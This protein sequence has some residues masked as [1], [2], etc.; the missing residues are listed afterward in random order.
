[1]DLDQEPAALADELPAELLRHVL[2]ADRP[3]LEV[4]LEGVELVHEIRVELGLEVG[5]RRLGQVGLGGAQFFEEHPDLAPDA[6]DLLLRLGVGR[7]GGCQ[8]EAPLQRLKGRREAL[9]VH[10]LGHPDPHRSHERREVPDDLD[11]LRLVVGNEEEHAVHLGHRGQP[12]EHVVL[13]PQLVERVGRGQPGKPRASGLGQDLLLP[14]DR[15][16]AFRLEVQKVVVEADRGDRPEREGGEEAGRHEDALG[17][18][19]EPLQQRHPDLLELQG[20]GH[21]ALGPAGVAAIHEHQQGGEERHHGQPGQQ[22]AR[23]GD[24]AEL[25]DAAEIGQGQHVE[26]PRGRQ[27]AQENPGAGSGRGEFQG[28]LQVSPEKQLLLVPEEEVDPVVDPDPDDDRDEHHREQREVPDGQRGDAH[29][30][31]QAHRQD[32][33]HQERLSRALEGQEQEAEGE[34]KGQ[35]RGD[36]AVPERRGHL[37]VGER[38]HSG[39]PH[40]NAGELTSEAGDDAPDRGDRLLVAGEAALRACGLHED[41]QQTLVVREEIPGVA[42][43]ATVQREERPPGR[44]VRGRVVEPLRDLRQQLLEEAQVHRPALLEAEVEELG[45]EGRGDLRIDARDELV[46]GGVAG[47]IL[48]ELLVVED[49]VADLPQLVRRKVQ[50]CSPLEALRIDPV[51]HPP[52]LHRTAL[53]LAHEAA[54]VG[55]GLLQ[56]ASLDHDRDVLELTEVL[57]VL[58]EQDG[59]PL[60]GRQEVAGGRLEGQPVQRVGDRQGGEGE[61]EECRQ[62]RAPAGH[63]NQ[64]AEKPPCP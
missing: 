16:G 32:A 19:G 3:G 9:K 29:R 44:A 23:P 30:P 38:G 34:R 60:A 6:F 62:A 10:G 46:E 49:L 7:L 35:E 21:G 64:L 28:F 37:V 47:E 56:G 61:G 20:A 2:E 14:D 15:L 63:P 5:E 39:D 27:R 8:V 42:F 45:D 58:A 12:R 13:S 52:E 50:E 41:E 40:L 33:E 48:H 17:I 1:M 53:D 51:G 25:F 18:P 22:D 4:S 54:G 24:E 59:V 36:L 11:L 43:L 26:G 31:G 57:A 55:L